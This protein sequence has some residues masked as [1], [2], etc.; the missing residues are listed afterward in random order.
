M[1][2]L[3]I[4]PPPERRAYKAQKNFEG[5]AGSYPW[6]LQVR[7]RWQHDSAQPDWIRILIVRDIT[8]F[9]CALYEKFPDGE[10][11]KQEFEVWIYTRVMDE[12]SKPPLSYSY[13]RQLRREQH[14]T[15]RAA[16]RAEILGKAVKSLQVGILRRDEKGELL[17]TIYETNYH[18]HALM[19]CL[20][21]PAQEG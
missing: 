12:N 11:D 7:S 8:Q 14:P 3:F 5:L 19:L 9:D 10:G 21:E 17:F 2:I 18:K 16:V 20:A 1:R 4:P 13:C 6:L 15:V